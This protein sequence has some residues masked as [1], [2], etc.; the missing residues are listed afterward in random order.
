MTNVKTYQLPGFCKAP[1]SMNYKA[2]YALNNACGD[3]ALSAE[4]VEK[5]STFGLMCR[6]CSKEISRRAENE[7]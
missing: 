6:E 3:P 4:T 5:R 2:L 1:K 7:A